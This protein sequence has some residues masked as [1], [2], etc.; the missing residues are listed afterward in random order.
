[1]PES[2]SSDRAPDSPPQDLGRP[3]RRSRPHRH[4]GPYP[5]FSPRHDRTG[6]RR[7]T[8]GGEYRPNILP[9]LP[10]ASSSRNSRVAGSTSEFPS[11]TAVRIIPSLNS[12]NL[13]LTGSEPDIGNLISRA[14]D[15]N[16]G[17]GEWLSRN[18]RHSG[19]NFEVRPIS[20]RLE[21]D[22]VFRRRHEGI[23]QSR[24]EPAIAFGQYRRFNLFEADGGFSPFEEDEGLRR[25]PDHFGT[26]DT[27]MARLPPVE[28]A[29][30]GESEQVC[31]VCLN[32]Y[33]RPSSATSSRTSETEHAVRLRCHHVLGRECIRQWLQD[34]NITCPLCRANV[35]GH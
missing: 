7:N 25:R 21:E 14:P 35:Y 27:I 1:M 17:F 4:I 8:H 31:P 24:S 22:Q 13:H 6:S 32:P 11:P 19:I 30:L 20:S 29:R 5:G 12:G 16:E 26:L 9:R 28:T 18:A 33:H 3:I 23:G 34:G 2:N 15:P 10:G